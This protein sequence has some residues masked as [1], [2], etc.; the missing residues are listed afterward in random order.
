MQDLEDGPGPSA[1]DPAGDSQQAEGQTAL[2]GRRTLSSVGGADSLS[3]A[4]DMAAAEAER[5]EAHAQETRRNPAGT[6]PLQ[7]NAMMLGMDP[8]SYVLR[9]LSSIKAVDLEQ[10][11]LVRPPPPAPAAAAVREW[12][13]TA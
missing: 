2:A 4:L 10:A 3:E 11:L 8:E 5:R 6:K 1:M 9:A 13:A 7:A 12:G